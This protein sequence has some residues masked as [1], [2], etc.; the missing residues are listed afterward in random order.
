MEVLEPRFHVLAPDLYG[1]GRTPAW[2]TDRPL[3]LHDEVALLDPVFVRAGDPFTLVGH[4]YG[5]AAA[6]VAAITYPERVRALALY[7]PTLFAVVDAASPPPNEADGIRAAVALSLAALDA[8]DRSG[9]A[10]HFI[11]FWMG[12]GA[13]AQMPESRQGPILA[14]IVNLPGWSTAL[15]NEP[16]PLAAFTQLDVPVLYM[17]GRESPAS[18]R[19]VGRLFT[20]VLPRVQLVEFDGVG[21]MGPVTHPA[22][23]NEAISRFL[24]ETHG[25]GRSE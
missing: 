15:L 5:A 16:T 14:S 18:S 25:S 9:A 21:H 24:L 1:A 4:S 12:E 17:M 11:D 7:E 6:L 10:R 8:G 23:I 2:P 22:V 3:S 13:W 19:S 20:G